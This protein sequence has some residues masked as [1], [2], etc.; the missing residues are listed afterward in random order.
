MIKHHPE[1][2]SIKHIVDKYPGCTV[3]HIIETNA[4][5]NHIEVA[6]ASILAREEALKQLAVL[7]ES[8][9]FKLPKGSTHVADALK[10]LKERKVDLSFFV[11]VDF[12]NVA[13]FR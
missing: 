3:R 7:S 12:K 9:G 2:T 13:P 5:E 4:D 6:A 8:A 1:Q 11:K 10:K